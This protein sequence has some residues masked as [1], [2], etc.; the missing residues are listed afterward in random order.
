MR[1]GAPKKQKTAAPS[2]TPL[3]AG[4]AVR[5]QRVEEEKRQKQVDELQ[6]KFK[7]L[8]EQLDSTIMHLLK[9]IDAKGPSIGEEDEVEK[10]L[11][12][13]MDRFMANRKRHPG[14]SPAEKKRNKHVNELQRKVK[15]R[16]EGLD[17]TILHLLKMIDAKGASIGEEDEVENILVEAMDRFVANRKRHPDRSPAELK[18]TLP[19]LVTDYVPEPGFVIMDPLPAKPAFPGAPHMCSATAAYLTPQKAKKKP[20]MR[21]TP[22]KMVACK[23]PEEG[24]QLGKVHALEKSDGPRLKNMGYFSINVVDIKEFRLIFD[25]KRAT[26]GKRWVIVQPLDE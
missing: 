11:V 20:K 6:R 15:K 8:Q 16:Q 24:W 21:A 13:A 14:R 10:I 7:Q 5:L 17:S 4:L 18:K 23:T 25:L 2:Q 26:Y 22:G 12:E 1:P 19:K 3:A 9:M